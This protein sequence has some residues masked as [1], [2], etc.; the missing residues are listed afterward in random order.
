MEHFFNPIAAKDPS[1]EISERYLLLSA[2]VK[3][4]PAIVPVTSPTRSLTKSKAS[5]E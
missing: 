2:Q 3:A 1:P 5:L 4:I